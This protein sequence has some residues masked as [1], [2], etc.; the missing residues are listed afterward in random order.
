M[1]SQYHNQKHYYTKSRDCQTKIKVSKSQS[2]EKL[3][4]TVTLTQLS[5]KMILTNW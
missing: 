4:S 5:G 1:K 2:M 3:S